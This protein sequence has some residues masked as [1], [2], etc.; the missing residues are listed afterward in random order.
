MWVNGGWKI[1]SWYSG[2]RCMPR[3]PREWLAP[4]EPVAPQL[5]DESPVEASIQRA[6]EAAHRPTG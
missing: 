1:R 3:L 6:R 4:S 2:L 5:V